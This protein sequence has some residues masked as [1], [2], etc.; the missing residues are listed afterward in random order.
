MKLGYRR[1]HRD[2]TARGPPR[3]RPEP[4]PRRGR[5][6][7]QGVAETP[8]EHPAA[9]DPRGAA[10]CGR[11]RVRHQTRPRAG[12]TRHDAGIHRTRHRQASHPAAGAARRR[13]GARTGA[14]RRASDTAGPDSDSRTR[15]PRAPSPSTACT[16]HPRGRGLRHAGAD[17]RAGVWTRSGAAEPR[18]AGPS[19]SPRRQHRYLRLHVPR[20][21]TARCGQSRPSPPRR[22]RTSRGLSASRRRGVPSGRSKHPSPPSRDGY[23]PQGASSSAVSRRCARGWLGWH[24]SLRCAPT[25]SGSGPYDP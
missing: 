20:A 5:G 23:R 10:R 2:G 18:S 1:G 19:T 6:R 22:P 16:P 24:S 17:A 14:R 11:R 21:P 15:T 4:H 3:S 8:S 25:C 13:A 9:P 12:A 7:T